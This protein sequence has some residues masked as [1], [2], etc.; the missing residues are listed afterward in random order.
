M[1]R[2]EGNHLM[3]MNRRNKYAKALFN[4]ASIATAIDTVA[5]EGHRQYRVVQELPFDLSETD[6]A[7]ALEKWLT[8]QK[9]TYVW[10][11]RFLEQDA[12]RPSI[13]T[14]YPELVIYW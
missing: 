9:F 6:A 3:A 10:R 14:E 8:E 7:R 5:M 12:F 4:P 13:A 2:A 1:K 11:P